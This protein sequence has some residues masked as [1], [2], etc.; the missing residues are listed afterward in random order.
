MP[1]DEEDVKFLSGKSEDM[2]EKISS[3]WKLV[4]KWEHQF[5]LQKWNLKYRKY[6]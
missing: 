5:M 4:G 1:H 2:L 3:M 6:C